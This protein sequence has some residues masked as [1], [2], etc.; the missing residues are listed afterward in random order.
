MRTRIKNYLLI[1]IVVAA[2]YG[3]MSHHI[4][5][6]GWGFP[7]FLKK[8]SLHLHET[9]YSISRKKPETIMR[10]EHLCNADIGQLLVELGEISEEEKYQLENKFCPDY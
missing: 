5:F 10:E 9:F 2:G 3:A 1:A 7:Y 4:I 8:N 6:D